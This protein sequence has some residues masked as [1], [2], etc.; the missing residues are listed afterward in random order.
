M[1][2]INVIA[3]YRHHGMWVF[4]D[5]RVDLVQEP[6][7]SGADTL[8]DR[9][10]QGIPDAEQGFLLIFSARPFPGQEIHLSWRRVDMDGNWYYT[11]RFDLEAWFCPALLKYFS[12]PP[13]DLFVQCKARP[14]VTT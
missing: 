5:P 4:D 8:I 1:N 12:D 2:A 11:E 10:V 3:P 7:I 13:K 14:Q 6:F 9:A